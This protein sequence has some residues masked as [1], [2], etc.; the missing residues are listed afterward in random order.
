[1]RITKQDRVL[2]F[3]KNHPEGI[4]S[5]KAIELFGAT[6]L[7]AIIFNLRDKGFNISTS[8]IAVKD[9]YNDTCHVALYKLEG[10]S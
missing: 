6:R 8:T 3:L 4:T 1:M 2:E 5:L 9:R 7:S 10:E